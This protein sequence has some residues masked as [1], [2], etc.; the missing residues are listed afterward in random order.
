MRSPL[1]WEIKA[2]RSASASRMKLPPKG[3]RHDQ[4]GFPKP[5]NQMLGAYASQKYVG[6]SW[7]AP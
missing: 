7:K 5:L 3:T 4:T 6:L 1:P 2:H